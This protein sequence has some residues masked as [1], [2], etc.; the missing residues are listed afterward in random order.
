MTDK[1]VPA[2][3][4]VEITSGGMKTVAVDGHEI[5]ICNCGGFCYVIERRCGHMNAPLELGTLDGR[6][7][8]CPMH[9]ASS[10]SARAKPYPGRFQP[11]SATRTPLQYW[12]HT[13]SASTS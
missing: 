13:S 11:T 9:C 10:T 12:Q 4:T 8:T 2:I 6:V 5:V 3:S 7:V 1:F